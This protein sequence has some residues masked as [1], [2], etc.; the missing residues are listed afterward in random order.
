MEERFRLYNCKDVHGTALSFAGLLT[1]L[2]ETGLH[3][4][5][6]EIVQP[7]AYV[8]AAMN[9]KGLYVNQ[10]ARDAAKAEYTQK[11]AY[12]SEQ[13]NNITGREINVNGDSLSDYLYG[14]LRLPRLSRASVRATDE[15]ALKKLAK[16]FPELKELVDLVFEIKKGKTLLSKFLNYR[17]DVDGR[18]RPSYRIG[19]VTGR[20]GC[21]KPNFMNVPEGIARAIF[22]APPGYLFVYA[23]YSQI[24][25]RIL[26]ILACDQGLLDAFARGDDIHDTNARDLFGIPPGQKVTGRQRFFAK[27]F[28]YRLNYG[29]DTAEGL[30]EVG[31]ELFSDVSVDLIQSL[32]DRYL[33]AHP[34][35]V[36]FRNNLKAQLYATRR[37]VN[38]FGRPRIFFDRLKD[39]TRSAYNYPMQSG[40]ADLIN[41]A[42][43][44]IHKEFPD[45]LVL[46]VHDCVML[47]VP[48]AQAIQVGR[49]VKEILEAPVPE[50]NNYSFP[51]KVLVGHSWGDF[52]DDKRS[53]RSTSITYH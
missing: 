24:E 53:A 10:E 51:A 4:F 44:R 49:R 6:N 32:S 23:D 40:A 17:L 13:L 29:G 18:L 42:M 15:A 37:I 8:L 48:E 27:M 25:L 33:A 2:E 20:L 31:A 43:I 7:L 41:K 47:E 12:L 36:E 39:A 26:A 28:I 22:C 50:L 1:E 19:P 46:Q 3:T 52:D 30:I 34:N 45:M 38:A 5:Y 14:E 9:L 21:K 16:Q 11:V 35:I